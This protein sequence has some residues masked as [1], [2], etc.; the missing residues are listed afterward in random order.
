MVKSGWTPRPAGS[1]GQLIAW[2]GRFRPIPLAQ[3]GIGRR[4]SGN[5][6]TR[7]PVRR[8]DGRSVVGRAGEGPGLELLAVVGPGWPGGQHRG[9]A[10][11]AVDPPSR[12]HRLAGACS[13]GGGTAPGR[14]AD[15]RHPHRQGLRTPSAGPQPGSRPSPDGGAAAGCRRSRR[16]ETPTDEAE[17]WR[18]ATSAGH[19]APTVGDQ[20]GPAAH[21]RSDL[22]PLYTRNDRH[23]RTAAPALPAKGV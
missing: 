20:A 21:S 6:C 15:R 7:E 9:L 2:L 8:P 17:C 16:S 19:E 18:P 10:G 14:P 4:P 22:G 3:R 12:S 5:A 13:T 1:Q 11:R 23:P